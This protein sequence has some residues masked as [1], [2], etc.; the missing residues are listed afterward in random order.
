MSNRTLMRECGS[1]DLAGLERVAFFPGQLLTAVD[2][3]AEQDHV[4]EKLRRHNRFLHGWGVVCGLAIVADPTDEQPWR[5]RIQPGYALDQAGD[6]IFV[7][8]SSIDALLS[9]CPRRAVVLASRAPAH[10]GVE[11]ELL[12]IA[13]PAPDAD[14]EQI[15]AN[16]SVRLFAERAMRTSAQ[17]R[18]DDATAE[19]VAEVCRLLC[20]LRLA[21]EL[22]AA[23][24]TVFTPEQLLRRLRGDGPPSNGRGR[25]CPRRPRRRAPRPR[26]RAVGS[27]GRPASRGRRRRESTVGVPRLA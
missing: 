19:S 16:A 15:R 26:F 23:R 7:D 24:M 21:I 25:H 20:G 3:T 10:H 17:F 14:G 22:A 11:L 8:P 9:A 12:P 13:V 6:E 2:L 18:L 1:S 27:P 4:R 5:V